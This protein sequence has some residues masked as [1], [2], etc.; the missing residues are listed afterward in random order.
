MRRLNPGDA[1]PCCGNPIPAD[2]PKKN[3]LLINLLNHQLASQ[4][5]EI[6]QAEAFRLNAEAMAEFEME[7]SL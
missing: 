4:R 6:T 2:I 7:E 5:G 1:C 3:L